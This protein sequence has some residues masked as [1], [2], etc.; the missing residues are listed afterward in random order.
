MPLGIGSRFRPPV[1]TAAA[2]GA[3]RGKNRPFALL[4][5]RGLL[6]SVHA[7]VAV[8][9]YCIWEREVADR[10]NVPL[11]IGSRRES[12]GAAPLSPVLTPSPGRRR[13][14]SDNVLL[15][16]STSTHGNM[17][18][19]DAPV[20]QPLFVLSMHVHVQCALGVFTSLLHCRHC[21]AM[22]VYGSQAFGSCSP[23]DESNPT[24]CV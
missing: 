20:P 22:T 12:L 7:T 18:L 23:R 11:G 16:S 3:P 19:C 10:M 5:A 24:R 2:E 8:V 21:Q 1:N 13:H 14:H 4:V 9:S 17:R 15:Y 6:S